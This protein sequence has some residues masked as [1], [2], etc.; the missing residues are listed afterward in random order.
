MPM[1]NANGRTSEQEALANYADM[2]YE[3]RMSTIEK[4]MIENVQDENF[5]T[6]CEDVH[7]CWQRIGF[8]R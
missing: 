3:D 7:G 8:G 1:P 6:L 2:K 4:L 5:I